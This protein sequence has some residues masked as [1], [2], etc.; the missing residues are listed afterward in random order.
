MSPCCSLTR[1]EK[2]EA[3]AE[4]MKDSSGVPGAR[5]VNCL[6]QI[7]KVAWVSVVVPGLAVEYPGQR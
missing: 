7:S 1:S 6:G 4:I 3:E 5:M 2:G